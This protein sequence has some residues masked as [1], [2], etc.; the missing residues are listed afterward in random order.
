MD[1]KFK[2]YDVELGGVDG[3]FDGGGIVLLV[4]IFIVGINLIF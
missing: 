1:K 3:L 4:R 2:S